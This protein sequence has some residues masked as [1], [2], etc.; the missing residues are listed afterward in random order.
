M[1]VLS[2]SKDEVYVFDQ[3]KLITDLRNIRLSWGGIASQSDISKYTGVSQATLSRIMNGQTPKIADF[4]AICNH[5]QRY[6]GQYFKLKS[7]EK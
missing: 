3:K 7:G 4:I 5:T 1:S 2:N 6:P